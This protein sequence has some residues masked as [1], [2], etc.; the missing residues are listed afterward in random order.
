MSSPAGDPDPGST[1]MLHMRERCF[2]TCVWLG[3]L[4][5]ASSG[6]LQQAAGA[7]QRGGGQVVLESADGKLERVPLETFQSTDPRQAGAHLVR[8]EGLN[9]EPFRGNP[10]RRAELLLADGD[11]LFGQVLGGEGEELRFELL[12][13]LQLNLMI[14]DIAALRFTNRVS[15]DAVGRMEAPARGDRVYRRLGSGLDRIDGTLEGFDADGVR[16]DSDIGKKNLS[17]NEVAGLFIEEI[18]ED[19]LEPEPA[20]AAGVPIVV[21]LLD[22]GRLRGLLL[23]LSASGCRM[24]TP[25]EQEISVPVKTIAEVF[26]DD[27]ALTF[28]SDLVPEAADEGSPFGDD[29]GMSWPHRRDRSVSGTLLRAGGR[30]FTRGIGVHAPSR[31]TW[32]LDG[33]WKSLRG[34]VAI[35]DQVLRLAAR[36]SVIF[37][38]RVDGE[39]AW[40][41][42][43]LRGGEAPILIPEQSLEGVR[44]LV[45]EVDMASDFHIADRADWLRVVLVK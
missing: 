1:K 33:N 11:L 26:V 35:D 18:D 37:R 5:L 16:I 32:R 19:E 22:Q 29:L 15:A 34:S 43:I 8:F 17:W 36:G 14:D 39:E 45:L 30:T 2:S 38:I 6:L 23:D 4:L 20:S 44:E 31:L 13:G 24:L 40:Q 25:F 7:G 27:G 42:R 12:G 28:L 9:R 21:D 10:A 41:S 3:A